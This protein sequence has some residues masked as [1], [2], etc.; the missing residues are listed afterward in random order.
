MSVSPAVG[1]D[2]L[3]LDPATAPRRGLTEWLVDR[4]R[5][6][7][8]EQMLAPGT[9]LPASRLLAT[10]LGVS[11]GVVVE[12]YR[13][14]TEE[15]L[16]ESLTGSGTRVAAAAQ[17]RGA[18]HHPAPER[19]HRLPLGPHPDVHLDL[20]PGRPDLSSFPRAAWLRAERA[21]LTD[22]ADAELG[23][24]DP[25][26][27]ARLRGELV[28]WL[29]RTRGLRTSP[30]DVLVVAGVAQALA[31]LCQVLRRRGE[32]AV[33][34]EDPGSRGTRDQLADWAMRAVPV[35][36]DDDGL[37]VTD[38]RATGVDTALLTPAHQFPT[39]VVLAPHRRRELLEWAAGGRLVI[40]DDY[41]AEQRYDRSPVPALQASAPDHVAHTGSTSKTLAPGLRLGWL[42][43][44]RALQAELVAAKHASD[45]GSPAL[46]Q[47]VLAH[48]IASG[49]L[50]R[51]VR[52]VR[53]RHRQ[54][55]DALLAAVRQHLPEAR[56][57]GIAAGMQLLVTFPSLPDGADLLL[58][59]HLLTRGIRV[60]PL[61]WHRQ[62]PGPP[63][64]VLGY[65]AHPPGRSDQVAQDIAA[66]VHS[67]G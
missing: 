31:L 21:V 30:A 9:V 10:D 2:F 6:A 55:R 66:A 56:V 5:T 60:H 17:R 44:P 67:L 19:L 40:E 20:S 65:A 63:G 57:G 48:L 62:L 4:L 26:G 25:R 33:A 58:A 54:R 38:L 24:G 3:Q 51:H 8:A 15:G 27:S 22:T 1:A 41:D 52:R 39:G 11:R 46:P 59:E 49:E 35:P 36:V 29:A 18:P 45:L 61:T 34:V 64:L 13:R 43:A 42:I 16:L 23:Y 47:L 32:T 14:L 53:V 37:R 28:G 12:A 50:E 7:V